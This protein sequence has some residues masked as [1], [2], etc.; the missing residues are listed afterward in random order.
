M[1]ATFLATHGVHHLTPE[2]VL[3]YRQHQ[4]VGS[5]IVIASSGISHD[6][7]K[8]LTE[9]YLGSLKAGTV[10]NTTSPYVGG[11]VKLRVDFHGETYIALA[12]PVPAAGPAGKRLSMREEGVLTWLT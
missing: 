4:F 6:T 1:G 9:K 11:D 8:H 3:Q 7:L 12:F 5:N 10:F 2:Q